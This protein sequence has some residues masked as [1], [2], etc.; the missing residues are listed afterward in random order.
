MI[1]EKLKNL[2]ATNH[3]LKLLNSDNFAF[4]LSFFISHL[5][6]M[7]KL[8]TKPFSDTLFS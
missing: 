2:K 3:T 7:Q 4:M 6:K 5:L 1:Y 8:H